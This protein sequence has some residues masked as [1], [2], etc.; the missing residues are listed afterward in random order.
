[1]GG[2]HGLVMRYPTALYV[3]LVRHYLA[4]SHQMAPNVIIMRYLRRRIMGR[5]LLVYGV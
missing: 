4:S 3:L 5:S 1:M 2:R